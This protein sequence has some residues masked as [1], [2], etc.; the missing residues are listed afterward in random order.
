[1]GD[2]LWLY[3]LCTLFSGVFFLPKSMNSK[4]DGIRHRAFDLSRRNIM[5]HW[6]AEK[7]YEKTM[8]HVAPL[9]GQADYARNLAAIFSMHIHR[10]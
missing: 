6:T 1:M 7:I 9:Q 4:P 3:G 2:F 8:Q 5:E 10:N